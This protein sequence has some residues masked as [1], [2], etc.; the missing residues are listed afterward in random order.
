MLVA[1]EIV[2]CEIVYFDKGHEY[3]FRC[4]AMKQILN[5][6]DWCFKAI[7]S[8]NINIYKLY[9]MSSGNFART[10]YILLNANL[11]TTI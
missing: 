10:V 2:T 5:S 9:R 4:L 3:K 6:I 8:C 7:V 11:Q 1:T